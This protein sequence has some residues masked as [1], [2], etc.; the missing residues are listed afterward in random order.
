VLA[1]LDG[2]PGVAESR[3]E[4]TGRIFAIA[5]SDGADERAVLAAAAEAFRVTPRRLDA[6][7]AAAQLAARAAGDPWYARSEVPA[8]CYVESRMLASRGA[9]S[10]APAAG[11]DREEARRLE[12]AMRQEL[13]AAMQRVLSEGGRDSTDWF[14]EEWPP[15]A[16]AIARRLAAFVA[17]ERLERAAAAL[18][19]LHTRGP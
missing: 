19:R 17:P 8:L 15:L 6:A 14:Y 13:F 5:L 10:V 4:A 11:L 18:A 3:V 12:D 9:R 2:I 7:E 16:A 1:R